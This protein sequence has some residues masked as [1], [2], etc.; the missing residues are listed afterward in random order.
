MLANAHKILIM[1]KKSHL[2]GSKITDK[3]PSKE[4][5]L[6]LTEIPFSRKQYRKSSP[7]EGKTTSIK[8]QP[9]KKSI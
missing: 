7:L 4:G 9:M 2:E 1:L 3:D 6:I 5:K 8:S